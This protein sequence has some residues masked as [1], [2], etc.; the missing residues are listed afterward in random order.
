MLGLLGVR[1]ERSVISM[2]MKMDLPHPLPDG[3]PSRVDENG[4][5]LFN[6]IWSESSSYGQ[7]QDLIVAAVNLVKDNEKVKSL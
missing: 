2:T 5:V 3:A 4:V 1:K 6:P 7:N